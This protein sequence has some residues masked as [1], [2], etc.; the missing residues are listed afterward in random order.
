[1]NNFNKCNK[2][3]EYHWSH[4]DCKPEYLVYYEPFMGDE[5]KKVRSNN[6]ENAALSFAQYYNDRSDYSLMNETINVK[7]EYQGII[8]HFN[9]GAE[10]DIHYTSSE[11]SDVTLK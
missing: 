8:K 7:V 11:I 4:E 1:M 6:H 5:P 3:G 9:V 2:C 10:P